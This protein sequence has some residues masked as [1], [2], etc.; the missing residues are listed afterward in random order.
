M[1]KMQINNLIAFIPARKNSKSIPNKNLKELGGKPLISYSVESALKCGL[2]TIVSTDDPEI[3]KIAKSYG[4]EVL[5]RSSSLA[6]D[7]TSMFEVLRAEVPRIGADLVLLLQPTSPLRK[8]VHIK[9]AINYFQE[10]LENY[11]SLVSVEKVP[12]RFNPYA[13]I[14]ET[15]I[16]KG[17]IFRKL[18]TWKEKIKSWWT[19][20]KYEVVLSG[21][22]ISQRM[23][24]RQD[25]P[26]CW[27][28]T[29]EIY[30]FK[31]S[32]LKEGSIYGKSTMLYQCEGSPNI[33]SLEDFSECEKI[34]CEKK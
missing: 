11:D 12:E 15:S 31:A 17:M 29:G 5:E 10:N 32:N 14:L 34:L 2:R 23:T 7:D 21:V 24:R 16:G 18:L 25:L 1:Q 27:L 22:P 30:C 20:K 4:V 13:M 6:K 9:T 3:A 26:Q 8:T 33:N 19:G 28:P